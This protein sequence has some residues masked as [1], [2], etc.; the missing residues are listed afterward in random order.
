MFPSTLWS[1]TVGL[2][3]SHNVRDQV[4]HPQVQLQFRV[5]PM[6]TRG[7]TKYSEPNAR[8]SKKWTKNVWQKLWNTTH[9][10][11]HTQVG[12]KVVTE[13]AKRW[14]NVLRFLTGTREFSL[15]TDHT[16]SRARTASYSVGT[17]KSLFRR[18]NGRGEKPTLTSNWC[19][20]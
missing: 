4:S 1:N 11:T 14:R 8:L 6:M 16:P 13:R 10:H 2:Q 12:N 7:K 9:T 3:C 19:R 20:S 15:E 17:G 18:L 5:L